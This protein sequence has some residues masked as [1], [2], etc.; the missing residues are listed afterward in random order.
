MTVPPGSSGT[1]SP[2]P[3]VVAPIRREITVN[4]SAEVAFSLFTAH[5]GRWWPVEEFSVFGAEALVA[6]EG[7]RIV[8]RSGDQSSVWAEVTA[9]DPPRSFALSWHPGRDAAG[10]TDLRISFEPQDGGT[11]VRL[12]HSGWE[13]TDAPDEIAAGYGTGWLTVLA[14]YAACLASTIDFGLS[15]VDRPGS[16]ADGGSEPEVESTPQRRPDHVATVE[17]FGILTSGESVERIRLSSPLLQVDMITFGARIISILA[18]D[19]SG[20]PG[21]VTLGLADLAAYEDDR[22][23]LGAT[24]GRYA[25]RIAGGRFT[26]DGE[27]FRV[28]PNEQSNA[29]HG[30]TRGFDRRLWEAEIGTGAEVM[31]RRSSPDGEMGF[32]GELHV[33]VTY[34]VVGRELAVEYTAETTAPTVVNLTNHAYFNLAGTGSVEDH[35]VTVDANHFL[36]VD[37][38]LIPTGELASVGGSPFDLRSATRIGDGLRATHPQ[39]RLA[40]GYDHTFVLAHS[41]APRRAARV[42]DPSSGRAMELWT[43]RPGVQ[44]YT[45]NFLDGTL[46]GRDGTAYRQTDAFCLEPQHFPDAPNQSTFPSTVLRPGGV[47][48]AHDVY[49]F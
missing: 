47:Y 30:G 19:A 35:L 38:A 17:P 26:L 44:F 5:I 43:D 31:M 12:V 11:L 39:L 2:A 34:R 21:E 25:N 37:E 28:P 9:W 24:V 10:A 45:G 8:E 16:R 46:V 7:D 23:Y 18:P 33:T 36:L 41:E 20:A 48:D 3:G 22:D 32:P 1:G 14:M 42:E 49:R 29:L 15:V 27:V 6:F 40:R 4:A 13:R